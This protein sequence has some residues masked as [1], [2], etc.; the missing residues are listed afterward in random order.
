MAMARHGLVEEAKREWSGGHG[1][2]EASTSFRKF[3]V[4][5]FGIDLLCSGEGVLDV[6]GGRGQLSFELINRVMPPSPSPSPWREG[7]GGWDGEGEESRGRRVKS[8]VVDA[9]TTESLNYKRIVNQHIR[10]AIK[11]RMHLDHQR[12][13]EAKGDQG[14]GKGQCKEEVETTVSRV[15]PS[16]IKYVLPDH[17]VEY[18]EPKLWRRAMGS[19]A[20]GGCE[21]SCS[22]VEGGPREELREKEARD[23]KLRES[24]S[25][26]V[27]SSGA[28]GV[29]WGD[30]Q[31]ICNDDL[32]E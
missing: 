17:I 8:T 3:L 29:G 9:R 30:D 5:T 21:C 28:S 27:Y 32:D 24:W 4:N 11:R 25:K 1:G 2:K 10:L 26:S 13:R 14:E 15:D 16:E 22:G 7:D 20:E 12:Q 19:A 6:A 31:G 18:F 23:A